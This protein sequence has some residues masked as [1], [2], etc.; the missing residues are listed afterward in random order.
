[1]TRIG[2]LVC[3]KG[4]GRGGHFHSLRDTVSALKDIIEPVLIGVGPGFSPVLRGLPVQTE[5]L[6]FAN[7][8]IGRYVGRVVKH[9]E[10]I[11]LDIVH[12]FDFESHLFGRRLGTKIKIPHVHTKCGGADPARYYPKSLNL[13]TYSAENFRFFSNSEKFRRSRLHWIP[14]RVIT[15]T[16]D[17]QSISALSRELPGCEFRI[18]RVARVGDYYRES[19]LQSARL[20]RKLRSDSIDARLLI[21]GIVMDQRV[22]DAVVA[23]GEGAID[24]VSNEACTANAARLLGI[25]DLVIGTG[26]GFM[27][28]ALLG[29][30]VMAPVRDRVF[31]VLVT[32]E[33]VEHFLE[34]NFSERTATTSDACLESYESILQ[35]CTSNLARQR[36]GV[37]LQAFARTYFD[38]SSAI[39]TMLN[40][41]R[42]AEVCGRRSLVDELLHL[43]LVG[44]ALSDS[45]DRLKLVDSANELG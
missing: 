12:T 25:A 45:F 30:P 10:G 20:V 17:W 40:V 24:F 9:C 34:T 18:C 28:A 42:E 23:E 35:L 27:E 41:Y 31:P 36:Y 19:L 7:E 38:I 44:K 39:P 1:M 43:H 6:R 26:R 29:K 37:E 3:T 8:P 21:I 33:N 11:A 14:N 4:H 15:P 13:I 32:R 2:F 16:Q 22:V 5:V